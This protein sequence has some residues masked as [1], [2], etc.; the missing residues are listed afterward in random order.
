[1]TSPNTNN[2]RRCGSW[3]AILLDKLRLNPRSSRDYL[4]SASSFCCWDRT[5]SLPRP[6]RAPFSPAAMPVGD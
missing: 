3:I 2:A 6:R 5:Q 1:M 4:F